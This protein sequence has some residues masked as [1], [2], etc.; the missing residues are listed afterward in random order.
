MEK[1][2]LAC[3]NLSERVK[4]NRVSIGVKSLFVTPTSVIKEENC[5]AIVMTYG[6]DEIQKFQQRGSIPTVNHSNIRMLRIEVHIIAPISVKIEDLFLNLRKFVFSDIYPIKLDN[7]ENDSSVRLFELGSN[8][9]YGYGNVPN[10]KVFDLFIGLQY[11][12][13]Y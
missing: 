7:G 12:D 2:F 5:P 8:G 9:P 10:M 1:R 13:Y 6:D 4:D 3:A 11:P